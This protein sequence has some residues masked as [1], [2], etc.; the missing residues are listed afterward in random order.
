MGF[1]GHGML[2]YRIIIPGSVIKPMPLAVKEQSPN[3]W[4]AREVPENE[5]FKGNDVYII[6]TLFSPKRSLVVWCSR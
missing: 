5:F 4:M 2:V 1:F 3:H 6:P